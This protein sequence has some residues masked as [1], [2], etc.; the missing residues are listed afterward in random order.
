MHRCGIDILCEIF[1]AGI[2]SFA[3]NTSASLLSEFAQLRTFDVAQMTDR[4]HD[5]IVGI[6]ILG[7]ELVL[8]GNDFCTA[9]I[10]IFIFH[11][12]EFIL[13]HLLTK[14]RIVEYRL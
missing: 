14:F 6:K 4:N 9:H 12:I 1:I 7:I 13:H 5:R 2:G 8:I 11:L 10:A 3:S